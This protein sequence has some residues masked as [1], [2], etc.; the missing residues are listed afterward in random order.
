MKKFF[1]LLIIFIFCYF[2]MLKTVQAVDFCTL[3]DDYCNECYDVQEVRASHILVNTKEEAEKIREEIINGRNFTA[4]AQEYSICPSAKQGG[5]LGW[6]SKGMMVPE[7][8]KAAFSLPLNEIS[9]P[10]QTQ[11]GWHLILVTDR[12]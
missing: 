7:F 8:E 10:V 9:E 4:A 12:R 2:P 11:Y 5:D 3:D 6:F 1:T